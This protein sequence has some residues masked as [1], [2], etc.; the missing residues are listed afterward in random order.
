MANDK[1]S[2]GAKASYETPTVE[3]IG[4]FEAVT[5]WAAGG[6]GLDSPFSAG[7]LVTD[8]TFSDPPKTR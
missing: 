8:L 7:T 6:G 5:Q 4:S 3:A 2:G 1:I